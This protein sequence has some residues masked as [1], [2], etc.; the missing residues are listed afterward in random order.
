MIRK[1]RNTVLSYHHYYMVSHFITALCVF[2]F[3]LV[4]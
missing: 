2:A 4:G 3:K 1:D